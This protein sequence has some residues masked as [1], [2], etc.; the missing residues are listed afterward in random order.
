ME[1]LF[2]TTSNDKHVPKQLAI[3]D[4]ALLIQGSKGSS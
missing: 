2:H 1:S 3:K 4:E